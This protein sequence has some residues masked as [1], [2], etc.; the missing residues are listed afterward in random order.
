MSF[1]VNGRAFDG[2]PAAGQCLRTFLRELGWFGVK[3]GCD[4]GDCG[5]CTV[6]L[7]G[8]PVHSCLVP[9]FRADGREVTTIEGLSADGEL[10]PMQRAFIDAQG[11]QCG[12]CTAGMIMTAASLGEEDRADLPRALKGNLC[13]CTGYRSVEDAVRGVKVI[14]EPAPGRSFGRSVPAPASEDIVTGRARYTL[15][16]HV[17]GLLHLKVLRSPHAHARLRSVR[18]EGALAVPGVVAVYTWEDVPRRLFSTANHDDFHSDPNDNTILDDVVR[19]VGDRVAAV[20]AESVGAAEEGCRRLEVEYE[21]LPA[22]FDPEEAMRPGAPLLHAD[23]TAM[24]IDDPGRN[25]VRE[26]HGGVGDVGRGFAEAD[27]V[28]EGTFETHRAQHAHLETHCSIAWT[29]GGR[30]HVRTSSQTPFLTQGKLAYLFDLPP[31]SVRVFCGRVGGGFG[32]KQQVVTEDLCALAALRT[33]RPVQ[34]EYTREEQF[35]ASTTRHQMAVRVKAGARRDGTL[36]ALE[37]RIVSNTG[38]YGCHGGSVLAHSA[39]ESVGVYRCPNKK[40]DAYAAY[41][42]TVPAGAFRGYGL[43]QTIFA[44]E[45]IMDDLARRLG[46]DP[47]ELRLR[48]VI[49]PGDAMTALGAGLHDVEYGSYGLDQCLELVR[50][51]L[52][53]GGGEALPDGPDWLEG[54]GVALAMIDTAPPTEHRTEARLTLEEDG[55]YRLAIGSPE[56]GNGSA[57]VR[58]Q[59]VA[60]VLQTSPDRVFAIEADTDRTGYDTGPFASAGTT[61]AAKATHQA[62]EALRGHILGFAARL[63]GTTPDRCRLEED[64]VSASD[65][66]RLGLAELCV[67]AREAGQ[68]VQAMRKAYGTP[69]TVAFN[70]QGFRIAVHRVTGEIRIL[71]SVQGVDAGTVI[72][73]AQLRGQVEGGIAQGLGWALSERMLL[74]G[75]GAVANPTFRHYRIPAFA[76][77]PRTEV[78]FARTSDAFG[79]FGAKSMSESPINPVAPAL[80]NALADATGLRFRSLPLSPDRIYRAIADAHEPA[81]AGDGVPA[82]APTPPALPRAGLRPHGEAPR[83]RAEAAVGGMI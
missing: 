34:W 33:G 82:G 60:T 55:R 12:F 39:N 30:L 21:A 64:A 22:V 23:K 3:K 76:D 17:E 53:R 5:A 19:H 14:E 58:Q 74:D 77:V 45:S 54:R 70:V 44:V 68:P 47:I 27:V 46:L 59:I 51:A 83:N 56:F 10:H 31:R 79:P 35:Q 50:E 24:R 66:R 26:L 15:D 4:A 13:R 38:A 67:A 2:Q 71:Q 43:S 16:V 42:N 18:K 6:W 69:R 41:T 32:G 78:L 65:G 36:T 61:V 62:A 37:L 11:F 49:R 80:A 72:N 48:N 75:R 9:A 52:A 28:C 40:I 57:T 7:D 1:R 29:D 73:P 20:V 81:G 63:W 8:E 25:I